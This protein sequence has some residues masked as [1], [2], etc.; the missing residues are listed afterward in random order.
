VDAERFYRFNEII[1]LFDVG[2]SKFDV[3]KPF[4]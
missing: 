3:H 1:E 2:R 4:I